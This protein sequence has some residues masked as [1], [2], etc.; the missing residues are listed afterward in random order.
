MDKNKL[1]Q[2]ESEIEINRKLNEDLEKVKEKLSVKKKEI[3]FNK[4]C[5]KHENELSKFP[6]QAIGSIP[7]YN[8]LNE[9]YS[10]FDEVQF[11]KVIRFVQHVEDKE[12]SYRKFYLETTSN[13]FKNPFGIPINDLKKTKN[14]LELSYKLLIVLAYEISGDVVSFNKVYNQIE[15]TGLFMTAPERKTQE[16]LNQ[17]SSKLNLVMQGLTVL[18][19]QLEKNND[20]L[21]QILGETQYNSTT[22]DVI[23]S[24]LWDIEKAIPNK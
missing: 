2:I 8:K 17:I 15:D 9:N 12:K 14:D 1:S 24:S 10:F 21:S 20:T 4:T 19:E 6:S 11:N 23:N 7:L 13:Y 3:T 22:L 5:I 16:Y 18:F